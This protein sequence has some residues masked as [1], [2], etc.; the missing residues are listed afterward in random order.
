M[1][2]APPNLT[3]LMFLMLGFS[4]AGPSYHIITP[5]KVMSGCN[6]TLAVHWFG[7]YSEIN[8]TATLFNKG[9]FL[10][11][12]S[13][14]FYK[15]SIG[16]LSLPALQL[17]VNAISRFYTMV[18]RGSDPEEMLFSY[19]AQLEMTMANISI[20]IQT[21]KVTY[22]AGEVVKIRA[23]AVDQ[24]IRPYSGLIDIILTD[25]QEN[26]IQQWLKM[27]PDLGVLSMELVLSNNPN[28]GVWRIQATTKMFSN[29]QY[30]VV[31]DYVLPI[32]DVSLKVPSLYVDPK[33]PGISGTV[34]ANYMYG[35]SV[36]GNVTIS[37]VPTYY[38][39]YV[40][41]VNKTYE[42]P[43]SVNFSFTHMEVTDIMMWGSVN[44]T[45]S[46]TEQLTGITIDAT[47]YITRVYSEY[48][49]LL[50]ER[51]GLFY[52]G[53]N[54]TTK[55]QIL[56]VDHEALSV[57]ERETNISLKITQLQNYWWYGFNTGN[58]AHVQ[59][60]KIPQDGTFRI[61]FEAL[62]STQMIQIEAEYQNITQTWYLYRSYGMNS[63]I[64]IRE[65]P[66]SP[67]EVGK[68]FELQI[69]VFPEVDE[70]FYVVMAKGTIVS[71]G[72]KSRTSFSLTPQHSWA[73]SAEIILYF[74]NV[75][76]GYG[77]IVQTS[78]MLSIKGMFKNKVT[79]SWSK[80]TAQPSENVLL[81]VNVTESR[82]LVGLRVVGKSPSLLG[83]END[84]TASRVE[85][86]FASYT[87][88]WGYNTLSDATIN[89]L[90]PSYEGFQPTISSIPVTMPSPS[91]DRALL[92][93]T[94]I[95]LETNISSGNTYTLP[96]SV[97]DTMTSWLASGFVISEMLGLSVTDESAELQVFQTFFVSLSL[98][99]S[100]TRGEVFLVEAI[101]FNH[102]TENLQVLVSLEPSDSFEI[103]VPKNSSTVIGQQIVDVPSNREITCLFPIRPTRLGPILITVNA[104]SKAASDMVTE[105]I[106]VKAEG[107]QK[108]YSQSALFDMKN[109]T[110]PSHP[111]S[112]TLSFIFPDDVVEVS[113]QAYITVIG[114]LLATSIDGL[115]SLIQMP[116]GCGEQNMIYFAPNIYVLQYL[117]ATNQ[118]TEYLTA[119]CIAFMKEGY[120]NELNY[121][122]YDGSFS[123]FGNSDNYGSTWL[124]AF[125]FR[126]F[127]QARPFI[128][129]NP[130]VLNGTVEWLVQ[131]QDMNTGV[132][133]EPGRV[134]H[135]E[136]QGGLNGPVTLT[137][138]ILTS[139]LEDEYYRNR[140]HSRV[141]KAVQYLEGKFAEGISSNY[142]FSV[143]V[144]A[145]SL[146][147]STKAEAALT[148]LNSRASTTGGSKYWSS[149][150]ETEIYYWQPRTTDIETAAYALLSFCQQNRIAEGIPV[151]KWLSQQRNHLGGYSSTQDTIMALQALSQFLVASPS[152]DTSLTVSVIGS[153]LYNYVP[154]TFQINSDN[155]LLLQSQ[156]IGVSQ[157][158][159]IN[160]TADGRGLA[161]VQL[162]IIYNQKASSRHRRHLVPSEA[163]SLDVTV[164]EDQFNTAHLSVEICT[165]YQGA[166][167]ESGMAILEVEFLSGFT[168]S[169]KGIP[170]SGS[171]KRVE[172]KDGEVYIYFDSVTTNRVCISVP[173]VRSAKVASSQ[174]AVI[175]I[176][177]YYNPRNSATRMYNS[178]TVRDICDFCG[179]DCALCNF[180]TSGEEEFN[181]AISPELSMFWFCIILLYYLF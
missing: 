58:D 13:D 141:Q 163:F 143:V 120:Q 153:D 129:I 48:M 154:K 27:K 10:I 14:V 80:N 42:I 125:V 166:G 51:T 22:T 72:K 70:L 174:E 74:H 155:L 3:V 127:L 68:A 35:K 159:S 59:Q 107:V 179:T 38:F 123:A 134:I 133:S 171:V 36:E 121:R 57:E 101:L 5:N 124:S 93:E 136:L 83:N 4:D 111:L 92:P 91:A 76:G 73:P 160:I 112:K 96:L 9:E 61:E 149:P 28:L 156:Q 168:M 33:Q 176:Y 8:V 82:S 54:Y 140:Y 126:C 100:V 137:A 148:Q 90:Y 180:N 62:Q 169:P 144:Y 158:L 23:V 85:K 131:Y 118:A 132:F 39:G 25:S 65:P 77:D 170:I 34:T 2:L 1:W 50:H 16:I 84:L 164:I 47:S 31:D 20:F 150:S 19:E 139:L 142:T 64:Q 151:M 117:V 69:E 6:T 55:M 56:R 113:E 116:C 29:I 21:D 110:G 89:T 7:N 173:M 11:S 145:L 81:S 75:N 103:F 105:K 178:E 147:N 165:S 87:K 98:P 94:W 63:F 66:N 167:N 128:Y 67:L 181:G 162:N 138:Y 152:S 175:K 17:P 172:L 24:N 95:W 122:R 30:F 161:I 60:Y 104:T 88:P 41:G 53:F 109:T 135:T 32:F 119:R 157:P 115:E 97:P 114:N 43:G 44:I 99:Y 177:D 86:S 46:V 79:L 26:I 52:P 108:F 130:D 12:E 40:S 146:A 49:L 45:A 18:V 78:Y 106:L 15:D 102:L 71:A 37:V